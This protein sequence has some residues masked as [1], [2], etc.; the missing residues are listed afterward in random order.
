MILTSFTCIKPTYLAGLCFYPVTQ[1]E[2][3]SPSRRY[4]S[5]SRHRATYR[6]KNQAI[7][8]SNSI[9]SPTNGNHPHSGAMI[10]DFQREIKFCL[11]STLWK[12]I[13]LT[14]ATLRRARTPSLFCFTASR[15]G[16]D[17]TF[18]RAINKATISFITKKR[19]PA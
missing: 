4:F 8:L 3:I 12:R 15:N 11:K 16:I 14:I 17:V 13:L 18:K 9:S 1:L 19:L 10:S 7:Y 6:K 5:V 2:T